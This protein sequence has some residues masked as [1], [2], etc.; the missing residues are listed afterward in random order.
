M[1]TVPSVCVN[2]IGREISM[3]SE[4]LVGSNFPNLV[5]RAAISIT[6]PDIA[7]FVSRNLNWQTSCLHSRH[8]GR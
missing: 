7:E 4:A 8:I 3:R 1:V 2:H 5:R 6:P